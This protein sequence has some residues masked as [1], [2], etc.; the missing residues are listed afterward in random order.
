MNNNYY[1]LRQITSWLTPNLTGWELINCFS[2]N[3]NELILVFG[4]EAREFFIR[5]SLNPEFSCLSFPETFARSR[6]NSVDLFNEITGSTVSGIRQFINERSFSVNFENSFT[7]LFKMHGSRSNILLFKKEEIAGL[8]KNKMAK[9][10]TIIPD[11][12]D[13][14]VCQTKEEF[15]REEYEYKKLFPTFGPVV[16]HYME[17]K[18][19]MD[20]DNDEKWE[21]LYRLK[22]TL[23]NPD[24]FYITEIERKLHLSLLQTGLVK[25]T[26]DHPA[27]ALNQFYLEFTKNYY[28]AREK[29]EILGKMEQ[30]LG[31]T[32]NYIIK[33][34]DKLKEL[35]TTSRH[36]E[37]ANIIMANI[38]KIPARTEE[39]ELF[40]FYQNQPIAVKLKKEQTPQKNAEIYY[41]KAKN[42][43]IEIKN[44]RENIY[45]K[46]KELRDLEKHVAAL[47]GCDDIK[48]LRNYIKENQLQKPKVSAVESLPYRHFMFQD[49]EILVG[50]NAKSND[51]LTQ[52]YTRKDD[53]WLHAKDVSGSH[54]VI[55]AKAGQPVPRP[56]IEKAAQ[57]AAYYSKRK[58]DTLCPVLYT[59]K[60][61][62]RKPKGSY[63]GQV[64]V[65]REEALL[66][67]PDKSI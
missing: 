3:K 49:Y 2:Q 42:Q 17:E 27:E 50:K 18:G 44:I 8:F 51:E 48:V 33:S 5:A 43:K 7:L 37:I 59:Q 1:F 66:V 54:V 63:P 26:F 55:R 41:R 61:Y 46:Q 12:L 20:M 56:V 16:R 31:R 67:A 23:E 35:E 53:L 64:V 39:I 47:K 38:H 32:G 52:K 9:D 11:E 10:R 14:F 34:R 57:L 15:V 19:Y 30:Q 36:E 65:D 28:L 60:K 6:K 22:N 24:S 13:R 21:F 58:N 29:T 62:V 25:K 4:S 40:D 45:F